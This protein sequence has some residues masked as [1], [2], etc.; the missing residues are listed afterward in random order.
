MQLFRKQLNK[1]KVEQ[2]SSS[3]IKN[4]M[5][6]VNWES[7]KTVLLYLPIT[8]NNEIDT[9]LFLRKLWKDYPHIK[10]SIPVMR[11]DKIYAAPISEDT[12]LQPSQLG[13]IEP[14]HPTLLP[15]NY[16]FD[17]VIV[18]LLAFDRRGHRLGYGK[19]H[20]DKFLSNIK[21]IKIG[22]AYAESEIKP[23]I[24]SENHDTA[25]DYISTELELLTAKKLL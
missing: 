14:L 20:Y 2:V 5:D 10:T 25:L 23:A 15:G 4:C 6:G 24:P 1:D 3:V 8:A 22:F 9:W 13:T 12:V 18:P 7:V 11:N 21:S 19:G 17:M 16:K